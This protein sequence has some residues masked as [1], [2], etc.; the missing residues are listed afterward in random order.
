MYANKGHVQTVSNK[1]H[2]LGSTVHC[3]RLLA[4]S[5]QWDAAAAIEPENPAAR[6]TDKGESGPISS[7]DL[8]KSKK[9]WGEK[10]GNKNNTKYPLQS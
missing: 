4:V 3:D 2:T 7:S 1:K 6:Q 9:L 10:K 8:I 5:K